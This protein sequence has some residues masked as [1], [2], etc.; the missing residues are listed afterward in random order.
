MITLKWTKL[1]KLSRAALN[2]LRW[3]DRSRPGARKD[4][5]GVARSIPMWSLY[6]LRAA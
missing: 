5:S 1:I 4:W 6:H 2:K 3:A